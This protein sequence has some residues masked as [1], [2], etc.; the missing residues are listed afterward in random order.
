MIALVTYSFAT[1]TP[2]NNSDN[3]RTLGTGDRNLF[4]AES[5]VVRVAIDRPRIVE[6]VSDGTNELTAV[7]LNTT[8]TETRYHTSDEIPLEM[9]DQRLYLRS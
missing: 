4:V 5:I 9:M 8:G 6:S 1:T 2:I 3:G 7:A